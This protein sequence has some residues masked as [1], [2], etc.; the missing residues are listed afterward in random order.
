MS[1]SFP[2]S[3]PSIVQLKRL[4][5]KFYQ[6]VSERKITSDIAHQIFGVFAINRDGLFSFFMDIL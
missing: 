5:E 3:I 1:F 6:V 4:T 2:G